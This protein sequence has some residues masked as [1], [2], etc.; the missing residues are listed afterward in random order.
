MNDYQLDL[1]CHLSLYE[2]QGVPILAL[3]PDFEPLWVLLEQ[4]DRPEED[5]PFPS[6]WASLRLLHYRSGLIGKPIL[7]PVIPSRLSE[8]LE[9]N[10]LGRSRTF[11][12]S[13]LRDLDSQNRIET[14]AFV[15][16]ELYVK[17]K[18]IMNMHCAAL[19]SGIIF[20]DLQIKG[21]HI[22]KEKRYRL[23][24]LDVRPLRTA[25]ERMMVSESE[26]VETRVFLDRIRDQ[27]D[28]LS[29]LRAS[30]EKILGVQG[31]D[32]AHSLSAA[33]DAVI[34]QSF[35]A[36]RFPKE[37]TPSNIHSLIIGSSGVGKKKISQAVHTL[38]FVT[39]EAHP[40]KATAAGLAG[41]TKLTQDG[42][43]SEPGY[44]PLADRGVFVIQDFHSIENA[45]RKKILGTLSM[46]M[47]EG[48]VLDSTAAK[49]THVALTSIHLDCNKIS[50]V[51]P[52]QS[53]KGSSSAQRRLAD[54]KIPTNILTRFD[55]II[56]IPQDP[57]I[58][59]TVAESMV[60]A[61]VIVEAHDGPSNR[62]SERA[63]Q[64][65]VAYV[66]H[67]VD[68]VEIPP[69]TAAHLQTRLT[70]IIETNFPSL[71]RLPIFS[72]F[73]TRMAHS[74]QK[75][76]IAHARMNL[77]TEANEEDVETAIEFIRPKL[78]FLRSV[79][80][81]LILET[82]EEQAMSRKEFYEG[83]FRQG[84]SSLKDIHRAYQ[85]KF[86]PISER[87][88]RR[89]LE[90]LGYRPDHRGNYYQPGQNHRERSEQPAFNKAI[91]T[92]R[93]QS[94]PAAPNLPDSA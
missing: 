5:E 63:L 2:N 78:E 38:N 18:E 43:V 30:L 25:W 85:E 8:G 71:Y 46:V 74:L 28:L 3:Q 68:R 22:M 49:A 17:L 54:I 42:F 82:I 36:G 55:F 1:F 47:E 69:I 76:T 84:I 4:M 27:T 90:K 93:Q 10:L 41:A 20:P 65:L 48:Q 13:E 80:P 64:L 45:Q 70:D 72:T 35:S 37:N 56:D 58:Q 61:P 87:Q 14:F 24:L 15:R 91:D 88:V 53:L 67:K 89:H 83:L 34:L 21:R 33:L 39:Q 19:V 92:K 40:S 81:D 62:A 23:F 59:A 6:E 51:T 44:I 79:E 77:R 66:V 75:V 86:G 52:Y 16:N 9:I 57:F 31:L 11:W 7:L 50:D 60:G 73:L 32:L 26:E 94:L 12:R 29:F